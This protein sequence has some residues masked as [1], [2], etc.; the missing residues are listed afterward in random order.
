MSA[1]W[2]RIAQH[3]FTILLISDFDGADATTDD[4][5]MRLAQRN[6]LIAAFVYDPLSVKL[7]S[8]GELVVS[9]GELQVELQ[10][11]REHIRKSLLDASD[12]RI[13]HILSWQKKLNIPVLPLSTAEDAATQL[14]YLLVSCH[15]DS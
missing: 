11:G 13:R 10:L 3:D 4:L 1:A 14:Q 2:A 15:I 12:R 9:N 6:D 8:L 5:L 7:P